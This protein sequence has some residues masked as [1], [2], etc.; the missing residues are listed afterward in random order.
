MHTEKI[1]LSASA[2]GILEHDYRFY[3]DGYEKHE[4]VRDPEL[5]RRNLML[6]PSKGEV[7]AYKGNAQNMSLA[8]ARVRQALTHATEKHKK[9]AGRR[10]K[11]N[12]VG[13]VS[14][15]VTL[16]FD[17]PSD[18]P[19][20]KFFKAAY[21]ALEEYYEMN[22]VESEALPAALHL[23]ETSPH[24]HFL[25]I[26]QVDGRINANAFMNKH[27]NFYKGMHPHVQKRVRELTGVQC[28][29]LLDEKEAERKALS[30]VPH[31]ELEHATRGI[32]RMRSEATR[33]VSRAAKREKALDAREAAL[34]ARE[35][36]LDAREKALDEQA[37]NLRMLGNMQAPTQAPTMAVDRVSGMSFVDG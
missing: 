7:T 4:H 22:G 20:T 37:R 2:G 13:L 29:V 17:W 9:T 27:T 33:A 5:T 21:Q 24:M 14:T 35:A 36:A 30:H 32:K 10:P 8:K 1:K 12:A 18:I 23:D 19:D 6:L 15:V 11:S 34:N 16:P 31:E 28:S 25:K 26:P 3:G